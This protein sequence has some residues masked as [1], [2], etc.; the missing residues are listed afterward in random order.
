[1]SD[2]P[3]TLSRSAVRHIGRSGADAKQLKLAWPLRWLP[4][5]AAVVQRLRST[6]RDWLVARL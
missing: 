2:P 5:F 3:P 4:Y 6:I 1:M